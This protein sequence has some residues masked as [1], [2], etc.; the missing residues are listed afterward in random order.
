MILADRMV[1]T[2]SGR[3]LSRARMHPA[4]IYPQGRVWAGSWR[5][6]SAPHCMKDAEF[7]GINHFSA[8]AADGHEHSEAT[9]G[10]KGHVRMHVICLPGLSPLPLGT[11]TARSENGEEL[12]NR[13]A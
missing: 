13:L 5:V 1:G 8:Q 6:A 10:P 4:A 9:V 12:I 3:L 7:V 2:V 11:C